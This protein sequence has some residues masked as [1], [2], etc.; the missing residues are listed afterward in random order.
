M[1]TDALR[2]HL[3]NESPA[4]A[5][6]CISPAVTRSSSSSFFQA[7]VNEG[8]IWS[9]DMLR[10]HLPKRKPFF[11]SVI[12]PHLPKRKPCCAVLNMPC[13][14]WRL[15]DRILSGDERGN[16]YVCKRCVVF[17]SSELKPCCGSAMYIPCGD[18]RFTVILVS[19]KGKRRRYTVNRYIALA[20]SET[21]ALLRQCYICP[22]VTCASQT[23][24]FRAKGS[25]GD[26]WSR[27][28][29]ASS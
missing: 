3:K 19:G 26:T 23:A 5:V 25:E 13:C 1:V 18:S 16:I 14:D 29:L 27:V 9:R 4:A 21:K 20:W 12:Y 11:G 8:D 10:L 22:A 2:L 7:K 28:A 17:A 6:L 24:C 15:T